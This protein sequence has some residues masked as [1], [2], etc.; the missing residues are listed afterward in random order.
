MLAEKVKSRVM[1]LVPA[2]N[3]ALRLPRFLQ[4]YCATAVLLSPSLEVECIVLD[5]GSASSESVLMEAAVVQ[6]QKDLV[7]SAFRVSYRRFEKNRGKGGVLRAGFKEALGVGNF[8]IIGFLD[9]DSATDPAEGCRLA[10]ELNA[11]TNI[12]VVLGSRLKCLGYQVERSLKRHLSGR[13]F[14]TLVSNFFSIPIYDSQCGAKFF[15]RKVLDIDLLDA[16]TNN[17]WLFDLQL[18]LLLWKRNVAIKEMPVN[19]RDQDGSKI[20]LLRDSVRMF[21]Q[22][23]KMKKSIFTGRSFP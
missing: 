23:W 1:I 15:R 12:D 16:C 3:E 10:L 8:D 7:N 2:Y 4:N 5:D 17:G 14:A 13:I 22:L 21:W 19:W 11:D 18:V 20:S 6:C 9:A